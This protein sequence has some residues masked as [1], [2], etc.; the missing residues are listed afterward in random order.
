MYICLAARYK[1]FL[2][3]RLALLI[4][5]AISFAVHDAGAAVNLLRDYR[6]KPPRDRRVVF[7]MAITPDE[8][9]LSFIANKD[10]RWRLSRVRGWQETDPTRTRR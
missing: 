3:M 10:G 2:S 1:W 5:L 6:L 7:A 4:A 8:D 9:V